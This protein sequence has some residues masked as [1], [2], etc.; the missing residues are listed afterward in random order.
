MRRAIL[1]VKCEGNNILLSCHKNDTRVKWEDQDTG[2][3]GN[4]EVHLADIIVMKGI[5]KTRSTT[6]TIPDKHATTTAYHSA[7]HAAKCNAQREPQNCSH[8]TKEPESSLCDMATT[9]KTVRFWRNWRQVDIVARHW[10]HLWCL[11]RYRVAGRLKGCIWRD[12][13][14][15]K[16]KLPGRK[17]R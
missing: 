16:S 9:L 11:E 8:D 10:G 12:C 2:E 1:R 5:I 4:I 17:E 13:L 14:L 7:V 3:Y 6:N 15:Y